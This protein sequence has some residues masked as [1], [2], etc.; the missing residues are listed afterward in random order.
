MERLWYEMCSHIFFAGGP[1]ALFENN[2]HLKEDYKKVGRRKDLAQ[3]L[4]KH[5]LWVGIANFVM[6]PL[7]LL[8]QILYA[9][10]S[11]AEVGIEVRFRTSS[12]KAIVS[13]T[14]SCLR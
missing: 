7:I 10:F 13:S 4:S 5:I 6:C 12:Q 11:Y 14:Y 3:L 2:W 9:F 8:W 1:W